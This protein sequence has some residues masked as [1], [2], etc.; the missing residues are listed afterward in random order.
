MTPRLVLVSKALLESVISAEF[1]EFCSGKKYRP[2][3]MVDAISKYLT[4]CQSPEFAVRAT[5]FDGLCLKQQGLFKEAAESY[6]KMTNELSDLRS[7]MLLEQAAYCYLLSS[8][9]L[10]RKYGFHIVLAGYRFTKT[11]GCKSHAARLYK[12]GSMVYAGQDWQLSTEHILYTLGHLNFMLKDYA[13]AAL[14]FNLLMEGAVPGHNLQQMVH[15]REYFL[16]QHARAKE[17][18]SVAVISLPRLHSQETQLAFTEL[19]VEQEVLASWTALEKVVRDTIS[20]QDSVLSSTSQPVFNNLT[21]NTLHPQGVVGETIF[22][23]I[24]L[25][26]IFNT[27][28]QLRKAYLLWKFV[29]DDSEEVFLNDKKESLSNPHVETVMLESVVLDKSSSSHFTFQLRAL[30]PG[31]LSITGLE[32][33]VKALFPDKEP[34]DHEIRGKQVLVIAPSHVNT[35]KDRKLKSGVGQDNRLEVRVRPRLPRLEVSLAVPD[36]MNCGE[37][38]CCEL[39]LRNT[40][41]IAMNRIHLVSQT[42]GLLSLGQKKK[43]EEGTSRRLFE[44]PLVEDTGPLMRRQ[45]EDGSVD[46]TSLDLLPVPVTELGGGASVKVPVWVR[47]PEAGRGAGAASLHQVAVYYDTTVSPSRTTPRLTSLAV[48][49][50]SQPSV[51]VRVSRSRPRHHT[52]RPGSQLAATITNSS[53]DLSVSMESLEV[54]QVSLVS[55]DSQLL[56]LLSSS[57]GCTVAR[58]ETTRLVLQTHQVETVEEKWADVDSLRQLPANVVIPGGNLHCTTLAAKSSKVLPILSPPHLTFIKKEFG[59]NLGRRGNPP[60]LARDLCVILWRSAGSN[61]ILG[62]TVARLED[63]CQEEEAVAP[64]SPVSVEVRM[65]REVVEHDFTARAQCR[66]LGTLTFSPSADRPVLLQY[67]LAGQVQGARVT[68][69]T[70]DNTS[71]AN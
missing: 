2:D 39:E 5:L 28:L 11:G 3:Y 15:L 25:E 30:S 23:K 47:G 26:N 50:H 35:V 49:L 52:N 63:V 55:R 42:P 65:V 43:E 62:Q 51:E 44:F 48:S 27:P 41:T 60:I 38:R 7:A 57:R 32:Y 34:T 66:V 71:T 17:D 36:M 22:V 64:S 68:G 19:P 13:G 24:K 6:I 56:S 59:H 29:P 53:K 31:Q 67:K 69:N 12:Q 46:Q 4:Q 14:Y 54:L 33:S 8:P 58:G 10:P 45:K 61:P 18:K 16:V 9:A 37:M 70:G 20:G 1:T 40:G 21:N